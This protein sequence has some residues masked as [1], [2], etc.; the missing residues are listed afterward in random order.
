MKQTILHFYKV[1]DDE[2]FL[3]VYKIYLEYILYILV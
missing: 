1:Q 2:N 3:A